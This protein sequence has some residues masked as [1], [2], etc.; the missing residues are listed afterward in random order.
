MQQPVLTMEGISK[1]F[2]GVKALSDVHFELYPGEVHALMGENGAGKS[3]LMKILSGVYP[4]T[5]GVIRL[6]GK[7]VHFGNPLDA[8]KQGVSIIHQEFNLF[9]NLSAAENIF[10]DRP[11][12]TGRFG[13]IEWSNMYDEAQRLID[14][15]GGSG[16]D[17]RKEVRH[18][19]VH[20]QQVV[21]I[22]KALSFQADVLIMDEPSA[23]LPENEVQKMFD[24]VKLLKSQGV[25]IVYV[26]HRMKEIFEIADKVTVLRDGKKIDTRSIGEVTEQI[27]IQM[28]VGKEV[29]QLYPV[30]EQEPR[31]EKALEVKEL[32]L[33]DKHTVSF[34][35]RKGE[36]LGLFGI[37]GSG[38]HTVAERL[39]GLKRGTGEIMV[40]GKPVRINRPGNAKAQKIA[41][42]PPDRHRQGIIKP[43]SIRQNI[44][45][46][47]L[48]ELSKG[49]ILD[50]RKMMETSREYME[51]LRIK[52]PSDQQSVDYLSGGNQQKVVIGKWLAAK[53]EILIL[54]EPTRGVDVGAKAEIYSI[55]HQL[56]QEGLSIL[57]IS[58]EMPEVI[59]LSDRILVL[60]KGEVVHEF[61]R[62]EA[63]QE[64]LLQRASHPRYTEGGSL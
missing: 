23:A 27:L 10:I 52:A 14:S 43:M 37:P 59:G 11:E 2:P 15:I 7:E 41:Y 47:N 49:P 22:A 17:V 34:G 13:R 3:T 32:S 62:G 51:K 44:S 33:D 40:G 64:Q 24:V 56:A 50:G 38:S 60:Y 21:E 5:R 58:S 29:N 57:L 26:S 18:L 20:S 53:P 42:V 30:R 8:Q 4:A 55:I 16:I 61:G 46:P 54:E 63:D 48:Q 25:A 31:E 12:I 35:L 28:M 9:A 6:K 1:E 36:I 39:F 45:I 19:G